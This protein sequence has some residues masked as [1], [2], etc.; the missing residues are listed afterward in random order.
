[1]FSRRIYSKFYVV[2]TTYKNA[3]I[4]K[5]FLK[6]IVYKEVFLRLYLIIGFHF[7]IFFFV[8]TLG[9]R[10]LPESLNRLFK[11]DFV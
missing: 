3:K 8:L 11:I 7:S 5:K 4:K 9:L 10:G 1:M 6:D 2:F